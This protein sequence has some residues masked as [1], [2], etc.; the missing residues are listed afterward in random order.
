A[1][2]EAEVARLAD[3]IARGGD[4]PALVAGLQAR[5]ERRAHVRATLAERERQ[6]GARRAKGDALNLMRPARADW[7]GPPP[8]G[9]RPG[10]DA[11]PVA[12][13]GPARVHARGARRPALLS[14][15][16]PRHRR[17]HHHRH[18]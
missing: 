15:R 18:R 9:A 16:G 12:P 2:L 14:L 17:A 7:P 13:R 3:A 11:A 6:R 1:R 5:E 4:L 10:P 8:P